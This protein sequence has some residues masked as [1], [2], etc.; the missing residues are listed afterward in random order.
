MKTAAPPPLSM[1]AIR[2]APGFT[3]VEAAIAGV[4]L[5]AIL[6]VSYGAII[7]VT[8]A[9]QRTGARVSE[10]RTYREFSDRI[11]AELQ[12]SSTDTD[13]VTGLHRYRTWTTASGKPAFAFRQLEAGNT[14]TGEMQPLWGNEISYEVDDRGRVLRN[15]GGA[16]SVAATGVYELE[17]DVT[18][19]GRF[20]LR[21]V[22]VELVKSTPGGDP[23]TNAEGKVLVLDPK[24]RLRTLAPD[25]WR[26]DAALGRPVKVHS[27][28]LTIR[29]WN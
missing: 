27:R 22:T 5:I 23:P 1:P 28:T 11:R 17:L 14:S 21:C 9:N 25:T 24:N 20:A 10:E 13:P 7:T 2:P 15:A 26:A 19:T 3:L 4:L 8:D 18:A 16:Q 6:A 12:L 29:P